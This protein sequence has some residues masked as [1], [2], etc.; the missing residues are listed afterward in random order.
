MVKRTVVS[1]AGPL[2][3]KC[4]A[5][6]MRRQERGTLL[7]RGAC[8]WQLRWPR[9]TGA[10]P[11]AR[12][13]VAP[14]G[15]PLRARA[16]RRGTLLPKGHPVMTRRGG[17]LVH[18]GRDGSVVP[19]V[20]AVLVPAHRGKHVLVLALGSDPPKERGYI[21][22]RLA[23]NMPVLAIDSAPTDARCC[24]VPGVPLSESRGDC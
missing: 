20:E 24:D 17:C 22:A 13:L 4:E 9:S 21:S 14:P 5:T 18:D 12:T 7:A 6:L 19:L 23:E 3:C 16:P 2:E 10:P 8:P 11:F 15:R 1:G